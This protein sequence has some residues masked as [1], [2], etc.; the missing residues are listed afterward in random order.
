MNQYEL[1]A[2]TAIAEAVEQLYGDGLPVT[3]RT[4]RLSKITEPGLNRVISVIFIHNETVVTDV[5]IAVDPDGTMYRYYPNDLPTPTNVDDLATY[6][7][8]L[9]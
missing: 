9:I 4:E 1:A 2:V 3:V 7:Y 5:Y 6:I 8:N